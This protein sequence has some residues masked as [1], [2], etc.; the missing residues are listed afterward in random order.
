MTPLL[1]K[2][3]SRLEEREKR[4]EAV[5]M[6]MAG[7]FRTAVNNVFP[8]AEVVVD[9]FHLERKAY[10][11]LH[12]VRRREAVGADESDQ[13]PAATDGFRTEWKRRKEK[14]EKNWQKMTP[15]EKVN[16]EAEFQPLHA[17]ESAVR[18]K[19]RLVE[20]L[21]MTDR[22]KADEALQHWEDNLTEQIKDD[23]DSIV[24]ALSNWRE[25][26][27]NYFSTDYTNV[28]IEA[29]NR[30]IRQ[31]HREGVR[32]DFET[33]RAKAKFGIEERR[34]YREEG[35]LNPYE[36]LIRVPL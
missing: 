17:I 27:L 26:I 14:L 20:I 28:F 30:S 25:E 5:V 33:L 18:A 4:L 9:R 19:K 32:M 34:R 3:R 12:N 35:R 31:M 24:N 6:D 11:D 23:F 22:D 8:D 2:H 29:T 21:E 36:D 16:L 10:G 15:A 7:H 1:R 13:E